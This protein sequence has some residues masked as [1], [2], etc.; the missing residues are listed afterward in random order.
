GQQPFELPDLTEKEVFTYE[1]ASSDKW[2]NG[3]QH[4]NSSYDNA[5]VR[6]SARKNWE[7]M[8]DLPWFSGHFRWTGYDYY[9]EAGYVHG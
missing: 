7:L 6:I 5:M 8:R 1:W 3:K 2:T 4:F 9:G